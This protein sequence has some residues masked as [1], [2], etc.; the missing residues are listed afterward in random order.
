MVCLAM[1]LRLR[2]EFV[3]MGFLV[4]VSFLP[5]ANACLTLYLVKAYREYVLKIVGF[6]KLGTAV[7]PNLTGASDLSM[8]C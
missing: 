7:N 6:T 4:S 5:L 8:Q 2:A 3:G 1:I